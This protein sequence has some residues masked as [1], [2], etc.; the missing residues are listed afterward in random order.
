LTYPDYYADAPGG[1]P[2]GRSLEPEHFD[3][4]LLGQEL[5]RLREP[6]LQ[7]LVVGRMSMTATE[8]HHLL[9]RHRGWIRLTISIMARYWS[10][11]GGRRKSKRDRCLS[12]GNA[13]VAMLRASLMDRHV[14]IWLQTAAK[15]IIIENGRVLGILAEKNGRKMRI[16]GEKGVVLAAGGFESDPQMR[17]RYLPDPTQVEW[18]TGSPASTGDGHRMLDKLG[19]DFAFMDEAWWGPT[20]VVPGEDRARMLVIEK[21]LP[22][23]IF[24]NSAGQRF[25]N[26]ASPYNEVVK[27]MYENHSNG[28]SCVPAYMVFDTGY[29]KKYPCGPFLAAAQQPDWMLPKAFKQGYLKKADTIE[30]LATQLGIDAAGL[31]ETLA[32][33]NDN[34]RRGEDPDFKR[35]EGVF[36]RYYGDEHISPN[37]CLAPLETP[38]Y[39]G[40]EAYAGELGTKG[41]VKT[42][43]KA[44]VLNREGQIIEGLY[45]I[46]NCAASVMGPVYPGAGATIGPGMT[47]GWIAA[48]EA[49]S[50]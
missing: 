42:D 50:T 15:E 8:A 28:A 46:G 17:K 35:G 38:P 14:P 3:G 36:D 29:R 45:A 26:E 21:G 23:C 5:D 43:E 30:A 7:E 44:R 32:R 6:A 9:A 18:T 22:G 12:L 47:F 2:G 31:K 40:I 25:V 11:V 39:Y 41:G 33:F 27:A 16:R 10:D 37:A 19:V 48:R 34:A 24:V 49:I 13:L 20:T 4:R 1:K